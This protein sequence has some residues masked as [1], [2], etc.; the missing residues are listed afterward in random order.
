MHCMASLIPQSAVK[1]LS[2]CVAQH[3][4]SMI[5]AVLLNEGDRYRGDGYREA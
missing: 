1:N 4:F 5:L 2:D 3:I